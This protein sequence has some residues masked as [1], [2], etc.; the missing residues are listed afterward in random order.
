MLSQSYGPILGVVLPGATVVGQGTVVTQDGVLVRDSCRAILEQNRTPAGLEAV[1]ADLFCRASP[2]ESRQEQLSLLLKAP[3]YRNYGHWL[4]DSA[5]LLALFVNRVADCN[6]QVVIGK[7]LEPGMRRIV[8]ETLATLAP[9]I[10]VFEHDD[11][12]AV[13]FARLYYVT[14]VSVTPMFKSPAAIQALRDKLLPKDRTHGRRLY[15]ARRSGRTRPLLNEAD[16]TD[17]CKRRGFEI[18]WPEEHSL[19]DQ[20]RMFAEAD[21][22]VGVKGAALTNLLFGTPGSTAIVLAPNNWPDSFFWDLAAQLDINYVEILG[23]VVDGAAEPPA[24]PFN[25]DLGLLSAALDKVGATQRPVRQKHGG[26]FYREC[27]RL[28]H[29][30]VR[31]G[32]YL[33]VDSDDGETLGLVSCPA[34]SIN[35][36]FQP[37]LRVSPNVTRLLLFQMRSEDFFAR[38]SPLVLLERRIDFVFLEGHL[39]E[40]A[41]RDFINVERYCD[42][43]GVVVLHNCLPLDPYMAT[44]DMND[45]RTRALSEHPNW[46]TGDVWK[47]PAI[48]SRYRPDLSV[49]A[50]DA[51]PTGLLLVTGLNPG[52]DTLTREF[53]SIIADFRE[54]SDEAGLFRQTVLA[55][56]IHQTKSLPRALVERVRRPPQ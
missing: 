11:A 26:L 18:V 19:H 9:G 17:L 36:H 29:D 15:V 28:I 13:T 16:V 51:P 20:A 23:R 12:D 50:F 38:Y 54:P 55:A 21:I 43:G 32:A 39:I 3:W 5:A 22:V 44:R 27:L 1:G 25:V 56:E 52:N 10:P 48:L 45:D 34:I 33:E 46:W 53:A 7:Q 37:T 31:P 4:I 24:S 30:T 41:V 2:G 8:E 14:P 47:M 6:Y 35:A 42:P 49:Q 40:D